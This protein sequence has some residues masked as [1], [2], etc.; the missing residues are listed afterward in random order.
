MKF[1]EICDEDVK[2]N[3]TA[4][5]PFYHLF[6]KATDIRI[7]SV[8]KG[9]KKQLADENGSPHASPVSQKSRKA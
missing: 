3:R 2:D 4:I 7:A 5:R 9:A 1:P 8:L 6:P